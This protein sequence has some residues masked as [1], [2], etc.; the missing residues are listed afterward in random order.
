MSIEWLVIRGSGLA[1]FALLALA[2]LW[3]L[4]LS[5]NILGR[6][7]K[8][9]SL[10]WFHESLSIGALLAT[11]V[12]MVVLADHDYVE[13]GLKE[14][15]LPGASTYEPVA[16]AWGIMAF[17][18]LFLI[19]ASFYVKKWIG[20]SAWRT[21]HYL[22]FGTFFAALLHGAVAGT[23]RGN[24]YVVVGYAV[25][26]VLVVFLTVVRWL[27]TQAPPPRARGARPRPSKRPAVDSTRELAAAKAGD[28]LP[29]GDASPT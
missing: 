29:E 4:F 10:N 12:H 7:V 2:T 28:A 8:T 9:K 1:A 24:P 19:T 6:A 14:L 5:T 17:Y 20:Q 26:V 21:I 23:D 16:V 27:Q 18:A 3:G 15:F 22:A 25:T 13:F 11:V